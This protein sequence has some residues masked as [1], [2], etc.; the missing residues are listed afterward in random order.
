MHDRNK[1]TSHSC[2]PSSTLVTSK[3]QTTRFSPVNL[4]REI[5]MKTIWWDSAKSCSYPQTLLCRASVCLIVPDNT[6]RA[7]CSDHASL[8]C[9]SIIFQITIAV[10]A[11][12]RMLVHTVVALLFQI[13]RDLF[14]SHKVHQYLCVCYMRIERHYAALACWENTYQRDHRVNRLD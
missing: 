3:L 8:L 10:S 9:S 7:Y 11:R 13:A 4:I 6:C 2:P 5:R 12:F 1:D 14:G